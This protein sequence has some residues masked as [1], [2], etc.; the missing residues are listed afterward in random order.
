LL[1]AVSA[2]PYQVEPVDVGLR[3]VVAT[4]RV[5]RQRVALTVRK[6]SA[7]VPRMLR[8]ARGVAW[9]VALTALWVYALTLSPTV[10]WRNFGEDSGDLLVA[11]ATLGIPHPTG[12]PLYVL[13]GRVAG[14]LPLGTVAFRINLVSALAGAASVYFLARLAL[15]LAGDTRRWGASLAAAS[16]ALLYAFSQGAWS[17]SAVAEVYTLNAAFL[18]AIL[19]ALALAER[20]GAYR[21]LALASYLFG[22]GLTNHLLLLAAAPAL[23]LVVARRL[24]ARSIGVPGIVLLLLLAVWGITLDSYL[25]IRASRGPEFSWGVPNTP[26]R[27]FWVLTGRQYAGNFFHRSLPQL[28]RHVVAGRWWIDFGWGVGLLLA[29]L[30]GVGPSW[31]AASRTGL[32]P[33]LA[34]LA[35]ALAL[36]SAY[37]IPDDV[38]YWMP[39]AFLLCAIAGSGLAAL[40]SMAGAR[41]ARLALAAFALAVVVL[42][43]VRNYREVDASADATPYVYAH[44]N[45]ETVEPNALIVSEYDGRTFSLW[46]Y[47]ATDFR[48]SHPN[49]VVVYKALLVW[50]W[51]LHHL[52]KRYPDLA[53]PPGSNDPDLLMNRLVAR[54]IERRPVYLVRDDPGLAR[55]FRL[56]PT[57]YPLLP[58]FRVRLKAP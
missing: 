42:G 53:V 25:P 8:D 26:D 7:T 56:E 32:L 35:A 15:T 23:A 20:T 14:F 24:A 52:A 30:V 43:V 21:P 13:L 57:G 19:W 1:V 5:A 50:P 46:F 33:V 41:L 55:I 6:R 10:A 36:V 58:I 40:W 34:A 12:Y 54:N 39:V 48:Q 27:L 47:K 9:V 18:G 51:Y 3:G 37:S 45:L 16:A 22:L 4:G 11:S 38:G 17:Q 49:L 44:R 2:S 28:V 31:R 29:G